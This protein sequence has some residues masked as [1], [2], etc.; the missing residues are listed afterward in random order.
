MVISAMFAATMSSL[1]SDYNILSAVITE[2]VYHRLIAPKAS[3]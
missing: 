3:P 2:D 1:D